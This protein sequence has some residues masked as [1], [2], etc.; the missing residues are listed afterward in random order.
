MAFLIDCTG[1]MQPWIN[2]VKNTISTWSEAYAA[3]YPGGDF[4]CAF[5]GYTDYDLQEDRRTKLL[6]FTT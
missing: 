3:K 1:S 6:D 5:V 4:R 2:G